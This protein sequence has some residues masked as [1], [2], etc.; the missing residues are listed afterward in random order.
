MEAVLLN[1][2]KAYGIQGLVS[3]YLLWQKYIL[4]FDK[5][6]RGEWVS[7]RDI[8]HYKR[9]LEHLED[10]LG[11]YLQKA[12]EE[13]ARMV[14]MESELAHNKKELSYIYDHMT[15]MWPKIDNVERDIKKILFIMN[16]INGDND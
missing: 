11:D 4:P 7:F 15:S 10:R 12:S 2:F 1:L 5:K 3:G 6:K 16:K 13:E 9:R 8:E 14:T